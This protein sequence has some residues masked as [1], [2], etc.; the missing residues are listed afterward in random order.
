MRAQ[1]KRIL[2]QPPKLNP[3]FCQIENA[4]QA[5][6][7]RRPGFLYLPMRI[8]QNLNKHGPLYT[9]R[10]TFGP[11]W[12]ALRRWATGAKAPAVRTPFC[13]DAVLDLQPGE[14]VKIKS[15]EEIKR[16]LDQK[17]RFRGLVFTPE[18]AK[19][20]GKTYQVYKRLELMFDEYH[21]TQR[22]VSNTVL[23]KDVVCE[24][25]GLGCHRS[26]FLYWRE[27]WLSRLPEHLT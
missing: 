21:K 14:W 24:G 23:L 27:A 2:L 9:A 7:L 20:C 3:D 25:A 26:C 5:G 17:G 4:Q 22:R 10:K 1:E 12:S 11:G 13:P 19:H 6:P 16:T 15:F 18:M 8:L